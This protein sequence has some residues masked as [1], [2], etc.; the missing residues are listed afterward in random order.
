MRSDAYSLKLTFAVCLLIAVHGLR[1]DGARGTAQLPWLAK[2]LHC[3]APGQLLPFIV[4]SWPLTALEFATHALIIAAFQCN[5]KPLCKH[6]HKRK[7]LH[8]CFFPSW[9]IHIPR[10][11][12]THILNRKTILRL[13][14]LLDVL[15]HSKHLHLRNKKPRRSWTCCQLE[16]TLVL[17]I[18]IISLEEPG[19]IETGFMPRQ[20]YSPGNDGPSHITSWM[21]SLTPKVIVT[22]IKIS[23][24]ATSK[25]AL[26][27]E[28]DLQG[29]A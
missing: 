26:K 14:S 17:E 4:P 20:G 9:Y 13:Q 18:I 12:W 7:M 22:E 11:C 28:S 19:R 24:K 5:G 6:K 10:R 3:L 27:R 16:T 8:L 21:Y 25:T 1:S 29:K 23:W 2:L 15:C